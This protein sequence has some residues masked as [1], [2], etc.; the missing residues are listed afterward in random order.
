MEAK[1]LDGLKPEY[2]LPLDAVADAAAVMDDDA[3][4]HARAVRQP[5]AS[6]SEI[7]EAFDGISYE[8]GSAVLSMIEQWIGPVAFQRGVRDYISRRS[9]DRRGAT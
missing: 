3:L 5:V 2:G 1:V 6:T 7:Q 8:K 9:I 4:A